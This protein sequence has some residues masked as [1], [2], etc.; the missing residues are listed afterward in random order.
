MAEPA[1]NARGAQRSMAS[2]QDNIGNKN[3]LSPEQIDRI[4]KVTKEVVAITASIIGAAAGIKGL[5]TP[6]TPPSSP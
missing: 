3:A 5:R 1:H 2:A 4:L 6:K